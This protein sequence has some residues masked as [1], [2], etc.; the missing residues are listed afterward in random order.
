MLTNAADELRNQVGRAR[1]AVARGR[2]IT[3][4]SRKALD[5]EMERVEFQS[6]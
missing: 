1:G 3:S 2:G 6:I 4:G 5:H